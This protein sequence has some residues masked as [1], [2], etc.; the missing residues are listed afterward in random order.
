MG[1]G[2]GPGPWR[3]RNLSKLYWL[4]SARQDT[5]VGSRAGSRAA[6][7]PRVGTNASGGPVVRGHGLVLWVRTWEEAH[8][9]FL[10]ALAG[11]QSAFYL[12]F[13]RT[14]RIKM[15]SKQK[16][17][18][19]RQVML[20]M[21]IRPNCAVSTFTFREKGLESITIHLRE[22]ENLNIYRVPAAAAGSGCAWHPTEKAESSQGP[23]APSGA[24]TSPSVYSGPGL[25][26]ERGVGS[27]VLGWG[28]PQQ[29]AHL[30]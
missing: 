29:V 27:A 22:A 10:M 21:G 11:A 23:G 7:G 13:S 20:V 9:T 25:S 5:S 18:H 26:G 15:L 4:Q 16:E 19:A 1:A 6:A 28:M 17:T 14:E 3:S 2:Q 30:L 8:L 24:F 12:Q